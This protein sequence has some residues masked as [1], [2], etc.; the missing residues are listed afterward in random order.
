MLSA[1]TAGKNVRY[2]NSWYV[3]YLPF[4]VVG[5]VSSLQLS[6]MRF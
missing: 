1:R 2:L 5:Y 6:V 3:M 4:F